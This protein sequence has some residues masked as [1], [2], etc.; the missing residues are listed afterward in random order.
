MQL[1]KISYSNWGGWHVLPVVT[2]LVAGSPAQVVVRRSANFWNPSWIPG[3]TCCTKVGGR[4]FGKGGLNLWTWQHAAGKIQSACFDAVRSGHQLWPRLAMGR[5]ESLIH[6]NHTCILAASDGRSGTAG[7]RPC[8][9]EDI[10][11][12]ALSL[13]GYISETC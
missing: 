10:N 8:C 9:C 12:A 7:V 4:F 2:P 13:Q 5:D 11:G 1:S 6:G 3:S